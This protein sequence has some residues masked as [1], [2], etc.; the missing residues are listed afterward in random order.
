MPLPS[1]EGIWR[2]ARNLI[3]DPSGMSP[4]P[5]QSPQARMV[6]SFSGKTPHMVTPT[7]GG[8]FNCD[9]NCPNWKSLNPVAELN[10]KLAEFITFVRKKKRLPNVTNLITSGMPRG[11]GRKV[12][13]PLTLE[14][15]PSLHYCPSLHYLHVLSFIEESSISPDPLRKRAPSLYNITV[16][17][18]RNYS[19]TQF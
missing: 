5:G 19:Y 7:Q 14:P 10:G 15:S 13:K 4:A 3:G 12:T 11:R 18:R 6:L 16:L 8:G 17:H 9:S 2:K 1:M